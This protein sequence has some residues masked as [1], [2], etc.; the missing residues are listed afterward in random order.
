MS[1]EI[2]NRVKISYKWSVGMEIDNVLW[3]PYHLYIFKI[4][5]KLSVYNSN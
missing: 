3:T 5:V 2:C 1:R 4:G